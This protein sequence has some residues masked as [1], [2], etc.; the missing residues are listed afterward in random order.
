MMNL[1]FFLPSINNTGGVESATITLLNSLAEMNKSNIYLV[2][3]DSEMLNQRNKLHKNVN[4]IGLNIINYKLNYLKVLFLI[5]TKIK[6]FKIDVFINVETISL[7]FTL[8][9]LFLRKKSTK[10]IVWEHFNFYNN[11]GRK[12]R[13]IL[14]KIACKFSDM[15]ITLTERDKKAWTENLKI[16]DNIKFIYNISPIQLTRNPYNLNSKKVV[17]VGRFVSVKGFERLIKSWSILMN[18]YTPHDWELNIVGFGNGKDDLLELIKFENLNN[19]YILDGT[20]NV[21]DRF[22]ESSI[23]CM[24]SF[25]EGLPMVLIEAQ[26]MGIPCISFDIFAGP[27]EIIQDSGILV[28]DGNLDLFADSIFKLINSENLRNYYSENAFVQSSRFHYKT[29]AN[30][31]FNLCGDLINKNN[32][33]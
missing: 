7:L 26:S 31:W 10:N 18:K 4:F 15:V 33:K 6:F 11:N 14:R 22:K 32:I 28:E 9:P 2:T 25:Y 29:I 16:E 1:M 17:S 8:I 27:S 30:E 13:D 12:L 23:Y 19:V 24:T 5:Y 3:F 20:N 21:I